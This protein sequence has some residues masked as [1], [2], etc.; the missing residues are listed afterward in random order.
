MKTTSRAGAAPKGG[1]TAR[2]LAAVLREGI[3]GGRFLPTER[4]LAAEHRIAKT[5][6]RRAL[7]LL[8]E[9]ELTAAE[10]C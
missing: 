1:R 8:E 4:E 5:T 7:K 10:P 3:L 6:A 9:E 2:G